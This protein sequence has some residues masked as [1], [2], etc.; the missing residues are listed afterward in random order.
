[1]VNVTYSVL[2]PRLHS[3][4]MGLVYFV[5]GELIRSDWLARLDIIQN[6]HSGLMTQRTPL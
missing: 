3:A 5:H 2:G 1:V 4:S 6:P